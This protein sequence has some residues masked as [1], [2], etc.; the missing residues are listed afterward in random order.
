[1][2]GGEVMLIVV[3]SVA[4]LSLHPQN[5]PGVEQSAE[6]GIDDGVEVVVGSLHPPK[7]PCE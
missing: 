4:G 3:V 7:Y 5:I 1:M 6:V 2:A